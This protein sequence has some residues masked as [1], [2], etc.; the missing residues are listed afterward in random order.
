MFSFIECHKSLLRGFCLL[1]SQ[2]LEFSLNIQ[3]PSPE[4]VKNSFQSRTELFLV[5]FYEINFFFNIGNYA[6]IDEWS[7]NF[8]ANRITFF[9][10]QRRERKGKY[11]R[12]VNI[13]KQS[14]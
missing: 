12:S 7:G 9:F 6:Q 3:Y 11:A 14:S 2:T 4:L 10:V 8:R 5:D 13:W 1:L